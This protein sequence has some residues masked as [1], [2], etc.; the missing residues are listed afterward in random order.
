M[1]QSFKIAFGGILCA[2]S[3][4]LVL[5]G[6]IPMAEYIG[7]TFAGVLLAWA[8][9]EM[10]ALQS[11][12]IYVATAILSFL[13]SGNKEPALLYAMFFGYFPILRTV[14]QQKIRLRAVRWVI[15]F[16]VFN[17]AMAAA[18]LLLV[19]V[20]GMPLEEMEGIGKYT[21]YVLLAGGNLLMV[22]VDF[23]IEKL[24]HLYRLKW[25]KRIQSI[26]KIN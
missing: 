20:F 24:S 4:I 5:L 23:C 7:P 6:N 25:Q 18:Y 11:V 12:W 22:A 21:I 2:F 17:I 19:Y 16:V 14:L 1:K 10:G 13:L 3:V 15:K 26:F 8:V 9:I